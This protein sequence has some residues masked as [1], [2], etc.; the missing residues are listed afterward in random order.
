MNVFEEVQKIFQK[1]KNEW[2][3]YQSFDVSSASCGEEIGVLVSNFLEEA[4]ERKEILDYTTDSASFDC[5]PSSN[6]GIDFF[7]WVNKDG[8]LESISYE[9]EN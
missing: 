2:G 1:G 3:N 7:A 9:W 8:T 4:K 6:P 5:G